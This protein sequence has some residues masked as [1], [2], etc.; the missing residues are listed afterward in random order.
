MVRRHPFTGDAIHF[1][2]FLSY[3]TDQISSKSFQ[4][5]QNLQSYFQQR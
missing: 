2:A 1:L 3:V 5:A 4:T